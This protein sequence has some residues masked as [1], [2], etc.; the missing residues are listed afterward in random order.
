MATSYTGTITFQIGSARHVMTL[1]KVGAFGK[2]QTFAQFLHQHSS[3]GI[4]DMA[5]I[6][7][8][9]PELTEESGTYHDLG[10]IL[11]VKLTR[12]NNSQR[13]TAWI[14]LPAPNA[15]D[16]EHTARGYRLK[17]ALGAAYADAYNALTGETWQ[18]AEGWVTGRRS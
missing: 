11:K 13:E 3:A 12:I 5:L 16:L 14:R 18:F 2:V 17:P 15:T 4:S 6:Q 9:D 8:T 7:S 10:L 1:P